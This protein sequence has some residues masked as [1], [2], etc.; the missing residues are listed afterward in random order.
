MHLAMAAVRTEEGKRSLFVALDR[1]CPFASAEWPEE[2]N[3]MRAAPFL[4]HLIAAVPDQSHTVLTAHG[5]QCTTRKRDQ[6]ALQHLVDRIGQEPGIAHRL[7]TS[8]HPWT[9]GQGARM[10]RTLKDATVKKSHD[11][12]H[13][14]LR[15]H[16]STFLMAYN[17][18]T[19]LNTLDGL[20]PDAYICGCWQ[21]EPER[22]ISNPSQHT[23][24][25]NN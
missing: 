19:R 13:H 5:L 16:W 3:K 21:K 12:T 24:G 15:A 10:T 6:Y 22:F 9:N 14:H 11:Q 20:T 17:C 4:R 2:A 8:N 25:L 7:T 18:A 23:L 1:V